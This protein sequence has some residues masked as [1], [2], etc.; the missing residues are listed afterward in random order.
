MPDSPPLPEPEERGSLS[1]GHTVVRKV[2]Q[3]A[4]DDVPGTTRAQ[5]RVA[6][7][8]VGAHGANVH[9]SGRDNDVDLA[10]D[11]AL[12]YPSPVRETASAVRASV[13][14]EVERITSYRVRTLSVTVSALEAARPPRVR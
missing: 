6:G 13:T 4:A 9:V 10:L 11:L 14:E 8:G 7:L 1:I 5:R 12:R 3:R 2:A